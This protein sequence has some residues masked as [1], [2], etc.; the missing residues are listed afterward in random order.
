MGVQ[1]SGWNPETESFV[2]HESVDMSMSNASFVLDAL[3][4]DPV[5]ILPRVRRGVRPGPLVELRGDRHR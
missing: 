3:G 4:L 2:D 5:D 1:F